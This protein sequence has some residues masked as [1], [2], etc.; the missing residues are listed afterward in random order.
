MQL[1]FQT[2]L[3]IP[4]HE[5]PSFNIFLVDEETYF[6]QPLT[7]YDYNVLPPEFYF[8]KVNGVWQGEPTDKS[9]SALFIE[10]LGGAV[11]EWE[12]AK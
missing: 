7:P 3:E 2:R 10:L 4:G 8:S 6:A 1:I 11:E 12:G 5:W 9:Y